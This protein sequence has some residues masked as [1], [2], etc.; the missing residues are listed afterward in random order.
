MDM[1]PYHNRAAPALFPAVK[2][3]LPESHAD[4]GKAWEAELDKQHRI[5]ADQGWRVCRNYLP[6]VPVGDGKLA[7]IV[8]HAGPDYYLYRGAV[9]LEVDAKSHKGSRWP[10]SEVADH[11]AA[12]LDAALDAG[13]VAGIVLCLDGAGWWLPWG[14]LRGRWR[15]W[16][17][18]GAARGDGSLGA[19]EL[20]EVGE[21]FE[22]ADWLAAAL[23]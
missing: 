12:D 5:Y 14:E 20:A 23:P 4:R 7:R 15:R 16:A 9:F 11:L 8:G 21:R 22:G 2:P 6:T 1:N 19:A 10:L 18:G 3:I 13:A 17:G